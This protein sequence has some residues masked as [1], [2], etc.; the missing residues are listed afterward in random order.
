MK[1][2]KFIHISDVLLG[3]DVDCDMPWAD[4]RKKEIYGTFENIIDHA[5]NADVDFMFISGNLFDHQP[6]EEE[7][8]WLDG[9][10]GSLKRTAVIY[11]AGF[12]D[13]MGGEAALMTHRFSSRVYVLGSPLLNGGLSENLPVFRDEQATMAMDHLHFPELDTD[14]YGASYFYK[15]MDAYVVDE[16]EPSDRS[17]HN[18]LMACGGDRHRM[19]VSWNRLRNNGFD[20]IAFGGHQ[21]YSAE[22][23]GK[24]YYSGSPEAVS[25]E[26]TGP[27]GYIYGELNADGVRAEFV[28][29]C[30]REY[31]RIDYTVDNRTKDGEL[32][33]SICKLLDK[34]GLR[35]IYTI[36]IIRNGECEKSFDISDMLADYRI[37]ALNGERFE[38]TDYSE[39]V[40]GNKNT[41]LGRLLDDMVISGLEQSSGVKMAVDMLIDMSGL[42]ARNN[43]KMGHEL[44]QNTK[45]QVENL[46]AVR[47]RSYENDRAVK[48]YMQIRSDYEVSPDVLDELN[49]T[50]A[51]ERALELEISTSRRRLDELPKQY[52]RAWVR[53]G[54]RAALVPVMI[55]G[56]LSAVLLAAVMTH[57]GGVPDRRV[58]YAMILALAATG[59]AY[60]AGY[61][62]S[63]YW[64]NRRSGGRDRMRLELADG[65]GELDRLC[66]ER[67]AVREKRKKLQSLDGRRRDMYEKLTGRER[68]LDEKLREIRLMRAAMETLKKEGF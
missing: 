23:A 15:K 62:V 6:S 35:N 50:W 44:F 63:K 52:R 54:I 29:V 60:C 27:H 39:Y 19:P 37:I 34:E 65:Q 61:A 41:E 68:E 22:I 64:G 38:R 10:L 12:C 11:L 1:N 18:I 42:Y 45:K 43:K 47:C 9:V 17:V 66:A 2:I 13:N 30:V 32:G 48:E 14:V 28:P 51:K 67:D 31:K 57:G 25:P 46:L 5:G 40:K 8:L 58:V 24:A 3:T 21:K 49:S 56:I 53:T 33:G 26:S 55:L 20:Y 59:M 4:E 36:N 7:L 16:A